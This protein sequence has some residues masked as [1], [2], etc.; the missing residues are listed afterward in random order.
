MHKAS[1]RTVASNSHCSLALPSS[2]GS[3]VTSRIPE[4]S[5]RCS[6]ASKSR[7]DSDS[8]R[9]FIRATTMRHCTVTCTLHH[10]D[11]LA[12]LLD[13]QPWMKAMQLGIK[14]GGIK[15]TEKPALERDKL[16]KRHNY[17]L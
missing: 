1:A 4:H 15:H 9:L 2:A 13:T 16:L 8:A 14:A 3:K 7:E 6:E 12:G 11:A 5:L 10:M 17:P